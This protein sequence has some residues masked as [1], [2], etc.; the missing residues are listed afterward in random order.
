MPGSYVTLSLD[1]VE[2]TPGAPVPNLSAGLGTQPAA[3]AAH[4]QFKPGSGGPTDPSFR[5][6]LVIVAYLRTYEHIG[7]ALLSCEGGCLCGDEAKN[8]VQQGS[9]ANGQLPKGACVFPYTQLLC[10]S[11]PAC[12]AVAQKAALAR[13]RCLSTLQ[14]NV[15]GHGTP[16][17]HA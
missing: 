16:K 8:A 12:P 7:R 14:C 4:L 9:S 10:A 5:L 15:E 1:A 2:A 11:G 13:N 17:L 6:S 3:A